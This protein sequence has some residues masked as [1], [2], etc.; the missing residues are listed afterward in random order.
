MAAKAKEIS[1]RI[2]PVRESELSRLGEMERAGPGLYDALRSCPKGTLGVIAEIK[3]RSPSAGPIAPDKN[4]EDQARL[5]LNAGATALSVLTDEPY[6]GGHLRDLWEV[7]EL[8]EQHRREVPCLRKDFMLHPVQVVEAAEAG[9]RAILII[10]RALT[11]EQIK[12]L[13]DAA[14]LAGLDILFELHD[15]QDL[16][17]S[18]AFSPKIL[19]VNNRDLSRFETRLEISERLIPQFP[20]GVVAIS[21]SGIKTVQDASRMLDAGARALLIGETLMRAE[22]PDELMAAFKD[23]HGVLD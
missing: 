9:A 16:E 18:L 4:A 14:R 7:T 10:M 19:G 1:D 2:R 15:E 6:F 17:R 22:D 5:Y 23:P 13:C 8:I 21:E 12:P 11:D 20:K 3:R